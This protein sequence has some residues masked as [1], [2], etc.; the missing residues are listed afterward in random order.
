MIRRKKK[1][2]RDFNPLTK[3]IINEPTGVSLS[4]LFNGPQKQKELEY[5]GIPRRAWFPKVSQLIG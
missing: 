2:R 1:R 4:W 5:V 3:N